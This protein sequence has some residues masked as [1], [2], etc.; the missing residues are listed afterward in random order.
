MLEEKSETPCSSPLPQ[1]HRSLIELM[2]KVGGAWNGRCSEAS[3][4]RRSLKICLLLVQPRSRRLTRQI[5]SQTLVLLHLERERIVASFTAWP[6]ARRRLRDP[7]TS[8]GY[9]Q[10][11]S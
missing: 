6:W 10:Y 11:V 8:H 3:W 9:H 1:A 5:P 4:L 7:V 2:V